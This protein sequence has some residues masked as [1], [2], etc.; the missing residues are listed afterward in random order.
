MATL[1]DLILSL[2][3]RSRS[4]IV[5]TGPQRSGTTISM[6]ILAHDLGYEAVREEEI[7]VDNLQKF[8]RLL[9][10]KER[11]VLQAPGLCS[12][13]HALPCTVVLVRRKIEQVIHSQQRIGWGEENY[14]LNKYFT[15]LGPIGCVKYYAW[16][17]Y[18]KRRLDDRAYELEYES[19]RGHAL[20]KDEADRRSFDARQ[21]S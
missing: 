13:A 15:T 9:D 8:F 19:L 18:Q 3:E 7:D 12:F 14:E 4:R 10:K 5:V 1:H 6:Q 11:F 16:N 17:V 20:W 21:T 2:R